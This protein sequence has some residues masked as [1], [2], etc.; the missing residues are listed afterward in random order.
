MKIGLVLPSVPGYSETFFTNKIKGLKA[1]GHTV[2]L[3]ID[4]GDAKKHTATEINLAPKLSGNFIWVTLK[5]MYYFIYAVLFH[6]NISMRL[7][8][9]DRKD[10][11]GFIQRVKNIVIN[12]NKYDYNEI[13]KLDNQILHFLPVIDRPAAIVS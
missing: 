1:A 10:G 4:N 6:F 9:L 12:H 2:I 13:L 7:Y 8:S 5:S 11:L 3:F